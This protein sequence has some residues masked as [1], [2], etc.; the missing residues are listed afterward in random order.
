MFRKIDKKYLA[1]FLTV[2]ACICFAFLLQN[3][4]AIGKAIGALAKISTPIVYGF[5]IAYL[6]FPVLKFCENGF[7]RLARKKPLKKKT[8]RALSMLATYLIALIV[9]GIFVL[10]VAPQV[11]SSVSALVSN[12]SEYSSS[13][14]AWADGI[15]GRVQSLSNGESF[16]SAPLSSLL[17][18]GESIIRDA[19][20]ML[21]SSFP[22][23]ISFVTSFTTTIGYFVIGVVISIY[24]LFDKEM[25]VARLKKFTYAVLP[26][27][28]ADTTVLFFRDID[29]SVGG[30]INSKLL[31]SLIVGVGSYFIFLIAGI[32]FPALIAVIIGVTNIIPVFGP[33]IGAIP[34]GLLLL[35][36]EPRKVI[37]FIILIIIIQ[38]IDGNVL[39]PKLIGRATGVS[40]FW[41]MVSLTV[42]GGLFGIWGMVLAV[43]VFSLL[44]RL[45]K[46]AV[47]ARLTQKE[48]A[49][50]TAYY[51]DYP[52][53]LPKEAQKPNQKKLR[54]LQGL[55]RKKKKQAAPEEKTEV[56]ETE[57]SHDP[58]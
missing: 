10:I 39:G 16:W 25:L 17:E 8:L 42:A 55:R 43:P 51:M 44:Y 33:I 47:N 35:I 12:F 15:I 6:L 53:M 32:K 50:D 54:F 21:V 52:P 37:L 13:F 29:E 46:S 20:S 5:V 4:S 34:S 9:I 11:I 7:S 57:E 14:A 27:K 40:G 28:G 23:V 3:L 56:S 24:M 18:S 22:N 2:A 31:D 30:F 26:K 49:A 45:V 36:V 41:V 19:A 48:M 1:I 38:Q 58:S